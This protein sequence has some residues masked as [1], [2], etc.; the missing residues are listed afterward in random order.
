MKFEN[1]L[2]ENMSITTDEFAKA[3]GVSRPSV[4]AWLNGRSF[5]HVQVWNKI[6]KW[7]SDEQGRELSD[8]LVE[9]YNLT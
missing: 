5:P 6:A 3:V 7:V 1:W 9:M 8:V 4:S 2:K